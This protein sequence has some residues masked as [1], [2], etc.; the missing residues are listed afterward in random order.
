MTEDHTCACRRALIVDDYPDALESMAVL[1]GLWGYRPFLAGDAKTALD[2]AAAYRPEIVLLDAALRGMT[3][4]E[5]APRLREAL[6]ATPALFVMISGLDQPEDRGRSR[7]A[8]CQLHLA[9]PVDPGLLRRLLDGWE[10]E[11]E[12][13]APPA[14]PGHQVERN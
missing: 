9:K 2:L 5:L 13:Q 1:L 6:G 12:G 3:G 14:P 4:W 8:G 11:L 10:K 7:Q